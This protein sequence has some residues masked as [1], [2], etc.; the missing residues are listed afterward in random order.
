M[1]KLIPI[2]C[3]PLLLVIVAM[4]VA[5]PQ[6]EAHQEN[7]LNWSVA[8]Y[9]GRASE[10]ALMINKQCLDQEQ[11]PFKDYPFAITSNGAY[12]IDNVICERINVQ[13]GGCLDPFS[14]GYPDETCKNR[15]TFDYPYGETGPEFNQEF[16]NGVFNDS[17]S[18]NHS[19]KGE[20]KVE[21]WLNICNI[22]NLIHLPTG[23]KYPEELQKLKEESL[24]RIQSGTANGPHIATG[25]YDLEE[26]N[27]KPVCLGGRNMTVD[28]NCV[29]IRIDDLEDKKK[30]ISNSWYDNQLIDTDLQT[31]MDS[32]ANDSPKERMVNGL[33]YTND[34]HVFMNHGC[35]WKKIG[36]FVGD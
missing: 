3:I 26:V 9:D 33:R 4:M 6:F 10:M 14:K 24:R 20:S 15:V 32:C 13:Q 30:P 35:E 16:C 22:R 19:K 25:S 5:Y 29:R 2:I 8:E 36:K 28:E 11:N 7:N 17:I 12:Y 31:V 27:G 21:E 1:N 23:M 34:T 18:V